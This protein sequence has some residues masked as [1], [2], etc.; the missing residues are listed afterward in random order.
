M[1]KK[2]VS[3][4]EEDLMFSD[5]PSLYFLIFPGTFKEQS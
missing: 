5:G 2:K 1:G 4:P 3:E